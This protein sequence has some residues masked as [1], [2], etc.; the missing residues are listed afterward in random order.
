MF[1]EP[2]E[3]IIPME[4][5]VYPFS[6]DDLKM[7]ED[8]GIKTI[9]VTHTFYWDKI[10]K[11]DSYD[12][13]WSYSD[14]RIEKYLYT[15]LKMMLPFYVTMPRWFPPDWYIDNSH[16]LD[17]H[18]IPNYA[19]K[20]LQYEV[21]DFAD[22]ILIHY[23]DIRDRIHLT[24]AI[25]A[26]GEFLWDANKIDNYPVSDEELFEFVIGR[27]RLLSEQY[28]EIW[29]LYHNFLGDPRNWN[30]VHLPF[31]YQ[32][33]RDEFPDTPI[34]SIQGP[35][36]SVGKKD[37]YTDEKNQNKVTEYTDKYGIKFFVGPD[38]CEGMKKN[39]DKAISQK[40]YGFLPAPLGEENT[41][42]HTSVEQWMVDDMKEVNNRFREIYNG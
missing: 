16:P 19:N 9:Y 32:A 17:N 35:H 7:M 28:N 38:Y 5:T 11:Q 31:L 13:D 22:E 6:I 2:D 25:P 14:G 20:E 30:N 3:H 34:Y 10:Q 39:I 24:Y 12:E 18:V 42:L 40:V 1:L 41:V 37:Y 27:Q 36:F 33:L 21:D 23:S 4:S 26:G 29:L 15:N 8:A